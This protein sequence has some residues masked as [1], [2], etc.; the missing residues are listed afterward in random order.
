MSKKYSIKRKA[1]KTPLEA[2][3]P[4]I[5]PAG[6]WEIPR[7]I[8]HYSIGFCVYYLYNSGYDTTDIYPSLTAG[9]A[10]VVTAEV[11]RFSFD[12]FNRIYCKL[13]GPLMRK[14]EV[15]TR[16]NGVVYYLAGCVIV[17]WAFPKNIA[18]LSIIYLSWTDPTASICGRLWGNKTPRYGNK[19]LAGT[20]G[21]VVTGSLVT[22]GFFGPFGLAGGSP[23]FDN[24]LSSIGL[25]LLSVYGGLVAGLSEGIGG[26]LGVDDNLTIP[27]LSGIFLWVPLVGLGLGRS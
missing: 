10:V 22:Y 20:L 15:S 7:K 4:E 9:F 14:T 26:V 2:C 24:R 16:L 17:L 19:S 13:L 11:L 21:A 3:F 1:T 12:W 6:S 18:S 23:S 5:Q 27:V 25:P 8:F